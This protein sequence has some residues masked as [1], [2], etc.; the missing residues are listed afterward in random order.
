MVQYLVGRG[1]SSEAVSKSNRSPLMYAVSSG[2]D[3]VVDFL[4]K[5]SKDPLFEPLLEDPY[6]RTSNALFESVGSRDTATFEMLF[7][8]RPDPNQRL[9][10]GR[11]LLM[12]AARA[13]SLRLVRRFLSMHA[14]NSMVDRDGNSALHHACKAGADSTILEQ[15][16]LNGADPDARNANQETPLF[17][18]VDSKSEANVRVLLRGKIDV[19]RPGPSGKTAF[20]LSLESGLEEIALLLK[21]KG[22]NPLVPSRYRNEPNILVSDKSPRILKL[23][24]ASGADVNGKVYASNFSGDDRYERIL[25]LAASHGW[26]DV[27]D[28]ALAKGA[29]PSLTNGERLDA[30]HCAIEKRQYGAFQ[31][32]VRR[33]VKVESDSSGEYLRWLVASDDS[34]NAISV[35]LKNG[36]SVD[37]RDRSGRTPLMIAAKDSQELNLKVLLKS[38]ADPTLRDQKGRTALHEA[39]ESG[40]FGCA[41]ILVEKG[42][43]V[44]DAFPESLSLVSM[45]VLRRDTVL[46]KWLLSKGALPVLA[47]D[48]YAKVFGVEGSEEI[49]RFVVRKVSKVDLGKA[50]LN[51]VSTRNTDLVGLLIEKHADVNYRDTDGRTPLMVNCAYSGSEEIR[52]LLERN[53]AKPKLRDNRGISA[54]QYC[55]PNEGE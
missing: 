2:R 18:A 21:D 33:G 48:A 37:D 1:A 26:N 22:A 13:N 52:D 34:L 23:L 4:V 45:A 35:L 28:L 42:A 8:L 40:C 43:P 54:E 19:D 10:D 17:L 16:L 14:D 9:R 39:I 53:G 38:K 12:A 41:K 47:N 20:A 30:L 5:K 24:I 51:A 55:S 29:D 31:N 7:A 36:A 44:K 25:T 27:I 46:A 6:R 32:L 50:L 11:T 15:L 49:A 3:S